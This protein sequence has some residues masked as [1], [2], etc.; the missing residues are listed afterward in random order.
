MSISLRSGEEIRAHA[1]FHWSTLIGPALFGAFFTLASIGQLM[2]VANAQ[3]GSSALSA[4]AMLLV[5]WFPTAFR[6]LQNKCKTYVVTNQRV[7]VEEGIFAKMKKDI[8]LQKVNDLELNQTLF[9][10]IFGSADLNVL[11]GNDRPTRL[12]NIT[13]GESFKSQI[14]NVVAEQL[15]KVS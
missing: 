11:T 13:G 7:Y 2:G 15:K 5:G 10:R 3:P 12:T 6:F 4:F 14:S 9:Q 8:P 1:H